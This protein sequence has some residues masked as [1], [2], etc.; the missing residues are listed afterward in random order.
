M[1]ISCFRKSTY[2]FGFTLV[3]L[4][5][6][7][8]ILGIIAAVSYPS[9]LN[10][11]HHGRINSTCF[12][13][14]SALKLA[15]GLSATASDNRVYGVI[16]KSDGEYGI[17]SFPSDTAITYSNYNNTALVKSYAEKQF[18][19]S[20]LVIT[21]FQANPQPF[22]I[23][24]RDDGVPTNDGVSVPVPDSAALIKLTSSAVNSEAVIKI[25]KSTGIAEVK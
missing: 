7:I 13:I 12:E 3:E 15:R 22:W 16:F 11:Y 9:M 6:V 20:S 21:N 5:T 14:I 24:F 8:V 1:R 19:D 18:I 25:S 23:I 17:Y 4:S 2:R 10:S